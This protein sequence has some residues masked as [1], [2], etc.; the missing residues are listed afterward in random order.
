MEK[1]KI[2]K[3]QIISVL[4]TVAIVLALQIGIKGL[5]VLKSKDGATN[6]VITQN[7][8]GKTLDL[9][10]DVKDPEEGFMLFGNADKMVG[11]LKREIFPSKE[12]FNPEYTLTFTYDDGKQHTY[13]ANREFVSVDGKVYRQSGKSEYRLFEKVMSGIYFDGISE[14][15]GEK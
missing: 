4:A 6:V 5:P 14:E 13:A 7:F 15:Y 8:S 2:A 1:R 3:N 9:S 11:V 12:A 10:Y